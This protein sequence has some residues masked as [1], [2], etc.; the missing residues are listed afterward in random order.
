MK[1]L[2]DAM[3]GKLTRFLRIFGYNTIY[4]SD[5]IEFYHMNPVPDKN[6]NEFAV[7]SN[8]IVIT[9]DLPFYNKIKENAILLEGEGVYNYL[10]QLKRQLHLVYEFNIEKARCSVCNTILKRVNNKNSIK[11]HVKHE[12]FKTYNEFFQ[13]NNPSC[14]KV[15][16]NGPHIADI[17]KKLRNE[18]N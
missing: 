2:T 15:F 7:G 13:C 14:Q 12:T 8:R 1:F 6:L 10:N 11:K 9:K 18:T 4:A 16:W 5:L 17:V 3:L